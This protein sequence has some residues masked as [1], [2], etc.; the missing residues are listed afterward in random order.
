MPFTLIK[1]TFHVVNYS[2]DGDS[3][4]FAPADPSLLSGLSGPPA[5]LN[6]RGHAQLR[7][8]AIDTLET[9]YT[10]TGGTYHQPLGLAKAAAERLMDF[11]G[12]TNIVWSGN[13]VVQ[14]SDGTA[15]YIL[16]R[17]VE[18]NRRPVAFVFAGSAPEADGASVHLD[19]ARLADSYNQAALAEGIAYPTFYEGLFHDLRGALADRVI[20]ARAAG[21]GVWNDDG[22]LPGFDPT[23][24]AVI[25]ADV[26]ILPKL[27]RRLVDYMTE[28]AT[29]VGFKAKLEQ[30]REPVLD[31][32]T[33]NFTHFDTFI[34][35][36]AG[37][38]AVRL[39]R[40]PELLVFNEMKQ[41]PSNQFQAFLGDDFVTPELLFN[42]GATGAP[43]T[44]SQ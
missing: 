6:A 31:L 32:A 2:P 7:I 43:L 26:P 17:A 4:R 22:T 36:A 41:R 35:Q 1:G 37:T 38:S 12:I 19:V 23:N 16:S 33:S 39:T 8:E 24:L 30:A 18:K 9:H 3:I 42:E 44:P 10:S 15:G 27:F 21:A 20:A 29:A 25:T 40:E 34:N 11:V 28:N 14:A 13:N 5:K